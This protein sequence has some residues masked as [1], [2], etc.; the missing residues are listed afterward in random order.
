MPLPDQ[1][2]EAINYIKG[3]QRK[4]KECNE[5]RE[6]LARTKRSYACT[7]S[8]YDESTAS[9]KELQI[10]IH[11]MGSNLEVI[12]TTGVDNQYIFCEIIRILHEDGA[13][14]VNANFSVAGNTIF[15]IIRA[16][17][18]SNDLKSRI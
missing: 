13:D 5:K 2:D 7:S 10:Q 8:N 17:V 14:V 9:S 4:L 1:I 6:R 3:L 15:H 16:E 12:L 11:E 18:C